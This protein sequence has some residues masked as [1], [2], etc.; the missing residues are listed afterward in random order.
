MTV[1]IIVAKRVTHNY[2]YIPGIGHRLEVVQCVCNL[3]LFANAPLNG[4]LQ[5]SL[6]RM[7]L[8][9]I[10]YG[11]IDPIAAQE[12]PLPHAAITTC[13]LLRPAE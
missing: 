12:P 11:V 1:C 6:R 13:A 2:S 8:T 10:S 3:L 4:S 7:K 9:D 5:D